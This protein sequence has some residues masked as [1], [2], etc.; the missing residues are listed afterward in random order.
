M[1]ET[2]GG[3]AAS[4]DYPHVLRVAEQIFESMRRSL[5]IMPNRPTTPGQRYGTYRHASLALQRLRLP[6]VGAQPIRD[7]EL[8]LISQLRKLEGELNE[9]SQ[10]KFDPPS[11]SPQAREAYKPLDYEIFREWSLADVVNWLIGS[12][13]A[14]LGRSKGENEDL[15]L[16]AL[17]DLVPA[18]KVAPVQRRKKQSTT[19]KGRTRIGKSIL[20][21]HDEIEALSASLIALIDEKIVTLSDA[22]LNDRNSIAMR[23]ASVS[24]LVNL[25]ERVD[26]LA[27]SGAKFKNGECPTSAPVRQI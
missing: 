13:E 3:Q 6:P 25:R 9:F 1:A 16:S 18:Q 12:L 26:A 2:G 17:R 20:A 22:R 15:S 27:R 14:D 11:L 7:T 24:D 5:Q 8:R 4:D 10:A 21:N 19:R 23:D